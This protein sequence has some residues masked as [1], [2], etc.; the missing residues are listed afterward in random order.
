MKKSLVAVTA[1]Y[2]SGDYCKPI[3]SLSGEQQTII[4]KSGSKCPTGNYSSGDYCKRIN[5]YDREAIP[6]EGEADCP[7][8]W[9]KSGSYCVKQ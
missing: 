5:G 1:T 2:T 6:R 9:R 4:Q 8:G 7:S 3:K